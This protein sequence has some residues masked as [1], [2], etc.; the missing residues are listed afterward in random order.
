MRPSPRGRTT[1]YH[2]SWYDASRTDASAPESALELEHIHGY[3]GKTTMTTLSK[4]GVPGH[5][6]SRG[7]AFVRGTT[8]VF[9]L[10]TGEAVFPASS[11]VVIHDCK[12][13]RQRFFAS[14]DEVRTRD[15]GLPASRDW[16][17]IPSWACCCYRLC[18]QGETCPGEESFTAELGYSSVASGGRFED[19]L[20]SFSL[21]R[22]TAYAI[23]PSTHA[24]SV[25]VHQG[26]VPSVMHSLNAG[27]HGSGGAPGG[28]HRGQWAGGSG[29]DRPSVGRVSQRQAEESSPQDGVAVEHEP[30]GGD[31]CAGNR[32]TG[33]R[34][35]G[36]LEGAVDR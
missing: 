23:G 6:V 29:G 18:H 26:G 1:L 5:G 12:S 7:A 31:P 20:A 8:N 17:A 13:N 35:T 25:Q 33:G 9:W 2:P 27:D 11:V 34:C 3:S 24:R 16:I 28:R 10:H 22:R 36:A 19:D 30:C 21:S 15:W 14:H 32:D 4:G